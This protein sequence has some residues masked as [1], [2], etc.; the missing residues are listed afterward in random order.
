MKRTAFA[1]LTAGIVAAATLTG[2]SAGGGATASDDDILTIAVPTAPVSLDT[3][4]AAG[5]APGTWYETPAYAG[6]LERDPDGSYVAGLAAEFGYVGDGNT[7]FEFTLRSDLK[8]AD[9]TP[10]T[11]T[12]A[13]ASLTYFTE[14][15]TGPSRAMYAPLTFEAV[16]DLTVHITASQP[17][18]LIPSL[19][20]AD[21]LGGAPISP[22]GIAD[23]SARASNT[24]GAGQY[25]LDTKSTVNGDTY[26]YVPNEHY[27][28]QDAVQWDKIVLKVISNT[29]Q[30]VQALKTGQVDVII[31]DASIAGTVDTA[32]IAQIE[33]PSQIMNLFLMDRDGTLI[34]EL[35]DVRVRQALNYAID[36]EAITEAA[37][38]EYGTATTQPV[39]DG[40]PEYGFDASLDS[41]YPYD[42]A[43]A[44]QLLADAGVENLTIS[45]T[46][47]S[48][49]PS[50][51]IVG[52][53]MASQLAEVGVTLDLK[54]EPDFGSWVNDLVSGQ[55]AS[56]LL[57]SAG[58][59]YTSTQFAWTPDA[60]MNTFQVSDPAVNEGFTALATA[61][62]D[63]IESAAKEMN[64]I[65]L[66]QALAIS[67][68]SLDA[69]YLYNTDVVEIGF[70]GTT[71]GLAP[72]SA[73]VNP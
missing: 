29:T 14:T 62:A 2:C 66:E 43:K 65:I 12:E 47:L 41:F 59:M 45:G 15:T 32:G 6:I 64:R 49:S 37:Y 71:G 57:T 72:V 38:G 20:T 67:V 30:Q 25:V 55:Y 16:D 1:L 11:A 8:F 22:A 50:D 5:G 27:W 44:K 7:D 56:T 61:P 58:D 60:V 42:P 26:T 48:Y 52:Q 51:T 33:A 28:D 63:E 19:L 13:A 35:A 73:W 21:M 54:P 34:P 23:E 17:T 46:Y 68:S 39:I 36:R 40:G 31:G 69:I 4:K 24:Y 70:I 53:A 10:L 3:L 18:P 9:G